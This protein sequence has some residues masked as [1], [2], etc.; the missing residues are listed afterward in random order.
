M[1]KRTAEFSPTN[2][3]PSLKK[4]ADKENTNVNN[5][6]SANASRSAFVA[7]VANARNAAQNAPSS[8]V[9]V[10]NPPNFDPTVNNDVNVTANASGASNDNT[11][12][13]FNT[14]ASTSTPSRPYRFER[15]VVYGEDPLHTSMNEVGEVPPLLTRH[16]AIISPPVDVIIVEIYK[17]DTVQFDGPLPRDALKL[18][19]ERHE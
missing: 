11:T 13:N 2:E 12:T 14:P 6:A 7:R 16:N 5:L 19:W 1:S 17:K 10:P 18:F 3:A 9:I 15:P 8:A 4:K